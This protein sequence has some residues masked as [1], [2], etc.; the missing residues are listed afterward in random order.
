MNTAAK[1]STCVTIEFFMG[2]CQTSSVTIGK[3]YTYL[4]SS[5]GPRKN[6]KPLPCFEKQPST[7]QYLIAQLIGIL[8]ENCHI[9][10][11]FTVLHKDA[12]EENIENAEA[13]FNANACDYCEL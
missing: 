9:S 1:D 2:Y 5:I 3:P 10:N 6:I 12:T 7:E 13:N 11:K 8:S 4:D